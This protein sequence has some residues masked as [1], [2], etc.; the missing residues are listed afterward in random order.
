[1]VAAARKRTVELKIPSELR[2]EKVVMSSAASVARQLGFPESRVEDVKTAVSEACIN[3]IEHGTR[4]RNERTIRI[5]FTLSHRELRID[6]CDGGE[7]FDP[8]A[9]QSPD[10]ERKLQGENPRGWGLFL[11]RHLVD[12]F[13]VIETPGRGNQV[14]LFMRTNRSDA[15]GER[16]R[17]E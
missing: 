9:V 8:E 6:V 10:I 16:D 14:T 17:G 7:G 12:Q 2:Y 11:M 15:E 5:R 3:A 4:T 13:Q 1:M